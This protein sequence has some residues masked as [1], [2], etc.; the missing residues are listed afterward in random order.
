MDQ[1]SCISGDRRVLINLATGS[2]KTFIASQIAWKLIKSGYFAD[3]RVLFLADRMVL[4]NQTYNAFAPFK[5][6]TG[7]PRTEI[8]GGS[9]PLGRQI[10]FGIYQGLCA[11]GPD[12]LRTFEELPPDYFNLIVTVG[13]G[14]RGCCCSLGLGRPA[15]DVRVPACDSSLHSNKKCPTGRRW[16]CRL[17][18]GPNLLGD[19]FEGGDLGDKINRHATSQF[20]SLARLAHTA[21]TIRNGARFPSRACP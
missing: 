4:R 5:E 18:I 20:V 3:K 21:Y 12:G 6:G 2:G 10:Y 8:N 19:G 14:S 7:D 11:L 9:V 17:T 15:Y 13:S 1:E 16:E